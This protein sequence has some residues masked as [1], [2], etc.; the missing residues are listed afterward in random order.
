[1]KQGIEFVSDCCGA[2]IEDFPDEGINACLECGEECDITTREQYEEEHKEID[3]NQLSLFEDNR[4]G[5]GHGDDSYS[6][7]DPGL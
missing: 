3:P 7:A 4:G 6:D 5:T 2:Q 1:M